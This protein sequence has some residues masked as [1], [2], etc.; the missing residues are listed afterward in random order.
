[1]STI[2]CQSCGMQYDGSGLQPGVQFQCSQCGQMVQI[3]GAK[4]ATPG[5][6]PAG[7][8]QGGPRPAGGPAG[9]RLGHGLPGNA[10]NAIAGGAQ[11]GPRG[12]GPPRKSNTGM[13]VGI[14]VGAVVVVGLILSIVI[15]M[16]SSSAPQ[17]TAQ[18]RA[19]ADAERRRKQAAAEDERRRLEG[20]AI[21]APL[22]A[23]M[24]MGGSIESAI[25][26][27]D[28]ATLEGMFDWQLYAAYN[29]TL[30]QDLEQGAEYLNSPLIAS[31]EWDK[32]E[33]DRYTGRYN[34]E[35]ARGMN[36]LND[37][38]MGYIKNFY[39]GAETVRWEKERS[40]L[41]ESGFTI[42]LNG[43]KYLGK[44]VYID[45]SSGKVKE[46][47]LGAPKGSTDVKIINFVDGSAT[48]N[49]RDL[50]AVNARVENRDSY[51]ENRD[52]YNEERENPEADADLPEVSKTGDMPKDPGLINAIKEL[53]RGN[54]L[55]ER[56]LDNIRKTASVTEKH[57]AM[58][59][60]IDMLIDAQKSNDRHKK[61]IISDALWAVWKSFVPSDWTSEDMVYATS[62]DGQS[63]S[64]LVVRRWLHVHGEYLELAGG[65]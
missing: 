45:L 17:Q 47:W 5:R 32:G 52:P 58:G 20:E 62:F 30:V 54:T 37:R 64:E 55:N 49:L 27:E 39:F 61:Q 34:G 12:Y 22:D 15:L 1:M 25:K 10:G 8:P 23:A 14:S 42:D 29:K 9:R 19:D 63:Q 38:V 41:K 48:N 13:F 36:S 28:E 46:F 24:D 35:A 40:A 56:R 11:Q 65:G 59:A 4:R 57:N 43:Q 53:E 7:R 3:G 18:E 2:S 50:E 60:M 44:I 33:D 26:N 21:E 51:N 16:D 31:G 6:R